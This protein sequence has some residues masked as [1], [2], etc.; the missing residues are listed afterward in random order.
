MADAGLLW[1]DSAA[2]LTIRRSDTPTTAVLDLLERTVWGSRDTRYRIR[3]VAAKLARLTGPDFLTLE[4]SGTL[5]AVCVLNRRA[6]RLL[7]RA[8]DSAHFVMLATEPALAGQGFAG[9]LA[10]WAGDYLR[11]RLGQPGVAYAYIEATTEYSI[12]ISNRIGPTLE[13]AMPLTVFSR[14]LPRDDDR[15][16]RLASGDAA[17]VTARLDAL[18]RGHLFADF[19]ASL[20]PADYHV[21]R[22]PKGIAAGVQ[23]EPLSWSVESLPGATGWLIARLLPRLPLLRRC[24]NPA[25]LRFLRFGNIL[26]EPG[27]ETEALRL[28]EAVLARHRVKLGLILTDTRSPVGQRILAA[29][30]MGLL[31]GAVNGS[32]RVVA[33]FK[34]L[35]AA[36]IARLSECPVLMSPLDVF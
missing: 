15:V 22:D 16:E 35:G 7:D 18:Y 17:E 5:A 32:T 11:R 2:G 8:A 24:L 30:R 9:L 31:N 19:D 13:A 28:M 33:G 14:L 34:G 3:D 36:E 6:T 1:T 25:D 26:A 4:K 10:G 20:I 27:R 29:G 12:R 23:A 21:L